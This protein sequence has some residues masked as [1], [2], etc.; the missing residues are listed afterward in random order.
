MASP[1]P[2]RRAVRPATY[3]VPRWAVHGVAAAALLYLGFKISQ[4]PVWTLQRLESPDGRRVA[5]LQRTEYVRDHLR[6]RVKEGPIW[7]VP[8]YSPAFTNSYRV[9]LGERLAWD[10][11]GNRLDL[12][13]DGRVV[14]SYD[15][16]RGRGMDADPADRW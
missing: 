15:F 13:I 2:G 11:A 8:Y 14:W 1:F 10:E 7:F 12:R 3:A 9:D 5:V 4:G 6:V 16:T